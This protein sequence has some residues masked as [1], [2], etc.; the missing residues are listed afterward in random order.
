MSSTGM[1]LIC[2]IIKTGQMKQAL[3]WG[4]EEEDLVTNEPRAMFRYMRGV[5]TA[6]ETSGSVIGERTA[7]DLFPLLDVEA[8]DTH[9]TL[10]HLLKL[11]RD[12]RLANMV[13]QAALKAT[14]IA[15]TDP[16]AALAI[17]QEVFTKAQRLDAG[18]NTDVDFSVGMDAVLDRYE[19]VK[20]GELV[21]KFPWPWAPMQEETGG[22]QEDDFVVFY[23]RPKSMKS[24]ILSYLI[25]QAVLLET[26]RVLVYTKEMT[27]TNIYMR[28]ASCLA[29]IDY[30]DLRKGKLTTDEEKRLYFWRDYAKALAQTPRLT[31]LSGKDVSGR[32]TVSW[33]QGKIEKHG[34]DVCYVDGLYLLSTS[35]PNSKKD[36]ERVTD[37]SRGTRQMI[38]N[39]GCP[40]VATMQANRKAAG[41]ERGELDE[42]A[43]SD[44]VGQDA[45][46][47]IRV[48]KDKNSPT[49]SLVFAGSREY[50]LPGFRTNGIPGR[51]FE[52]HS[53]L[54]EHEIEK[55]Q[56][57]DAPQDEP[58]KSRRQLRGS[59]H[60]QPADQQALLSGI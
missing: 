29:E 47:I 2:K 15:R 31:V 7:K 26:Q 38:F 28:I 21:G 5:F 34:A 17:Y 39:T 60:G 45:T 10:D 35:N 12:E 44:A 14:E 4:L 22:V 43:H 37:I 49:L 59:S 11:V 30:S 53:L 25:S 40:V 36:H 48:I 42:L 52:L 6:P 51:N 23:G 3:E 55:A 24:W 32:D 50:Y 46:A 13:Q 57:A 16:A 18:R 54:T 58:A 41:H 20:R 8:V 9:M 56:A 19:K 33:L 27:P 1:Q